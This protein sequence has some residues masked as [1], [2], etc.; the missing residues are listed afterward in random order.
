MTF[1]D[2]GVNQQAFQINLWVIRQ[3][4]TKIVKQRKLVTLEEAFSV[5]LL[6]TDQE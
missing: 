2:K 6:Q 5:K 1:K 4:I 3:F